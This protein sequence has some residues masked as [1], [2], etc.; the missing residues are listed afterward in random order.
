M[1]LSRRPSHTYEREEVELQRLEH[2]VELKLAYCDR[3]NRLATLTTDD[4][5]QAISA[6][7]GKYVRE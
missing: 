4:K 1:A 3:M 2:S 7:L 6:H 5:M